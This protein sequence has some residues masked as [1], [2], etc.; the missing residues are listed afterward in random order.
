[1]V[2]V[3]ASFT[4]RYRGNFHKKKIP[5]FRLQGSRKDNERLAA[6]CSINALVFFRKVHSSVLAGVTGFPETGRDLFSLTN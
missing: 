2:S 1:V 4:S 6:W 5:E 3:L